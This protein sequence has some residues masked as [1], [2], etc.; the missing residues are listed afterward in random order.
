MPVIKDP[1]KEIQLGAV[2]IVMAVVG[3]VF[4]IEGKNHIP[5]QYSCYYNAHERIQT[6]TYREGP[7]KRA[8]LVTDTR[9]GRAV[10]WFG[11]R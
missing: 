3:P 6:W 9:N 8:E 11:W 5:Y 10:L 2:R 1:P 7:V 4:T